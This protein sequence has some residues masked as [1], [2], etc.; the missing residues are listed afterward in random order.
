MPHLR[1]AANKQT[2]VCYAITVEGL[3]LPVIDIT[4]PAFAEAVLTDA[5]L[6]ARFLRFLTRSPFRR[7]P[8]FLRQRLMARMMRGSLVGQV[9]QQARGTFVSGT[10]TYIMKLGPGMLGTVSTRSID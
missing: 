8:K 4:H 3:E 2:G 10:S 9:M 5:D 7:L 1:L 6:Q